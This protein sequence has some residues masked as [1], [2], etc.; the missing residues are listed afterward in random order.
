[1]KSFLMILAASIVVSTTSFAATDSASDWSRKFA[2]PE[3]VLAGFQS[4]FAEIGAKDPRSLFLQVYI[5]ISEEMWVM[6]SRHEFKN[7]AWIKD[8]MTGYANLYRESF[9]NDEIKN[10]LISEAWRKAFQAPR[11]WPDLPSMTLLLSIN[12][13]VNRDLPVALDRLTVDFKDRSIQTDFKKIASSFSRRLPAIWNLLESYEQCL[14]GS[15]QEALIKSLIMGVMVYQ[16][17][18]SWNTSKRYYGIR[19]TEA[20]ES[21]MKTFVEAYAAREGHQISTLGEKLVHTDRAF[22]RPVK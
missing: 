1:M 11:L 8:L 18:Q 12:A 6:L 13:H 5:Q 2:N 15:T 3:G 4:K 16:R 22:C 17:G 14:R 10:P 20:R 7:E 21:Q 9:Y 19:E